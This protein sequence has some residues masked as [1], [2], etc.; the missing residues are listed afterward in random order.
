[1]RQGSTKEAF[2]RRGIPFGGQQKIDRLS[3]GVDRSIEKSLLALHFN[4]GFIE[5]PT[6]VGWLQVPPTALVQLWTVDLDPAPD[7]TGT[8]GH[9]SFHRHL[10]H[11][12][13]RNWV[14]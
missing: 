2:G 12:C 1:M 5:A 13:R 11:L 9:A 3:S 8:D 6:L 4:I 10:R 7:T 14:S